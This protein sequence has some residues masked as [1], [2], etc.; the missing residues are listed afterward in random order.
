MI[1]Q[2]TELLNKRLEY[3]WQSRCCLDVKTPHI[4]WPGSGKKYS[5]QYDG[6]AC[7]HVTVQGKL[8]KIPTSM[9][10]NDYKEYFEDIFTK[11]QFEYLPVE[12]G[13]IFSPDHWYNNTISTIFNGYHYYIKKR[14]FKS[15]ISLVYDMIDM[16]IKDRCTKYYTDKKFFETYWFTE[17]TDIK[18]IREF[19]NR[20]AFM[21]V[22]GIYKGKK[23]YG[24]LTWEN[25]D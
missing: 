22:S 1:P 16:T 12:V 25:C 14:K 5:I 9:R 23:K 2:I 21:L 6:C 17:Y 3:K 13:S 18:I 4:I 11:K 24:I 8:W 15:V 10:Q 20:E 7:S 19:E